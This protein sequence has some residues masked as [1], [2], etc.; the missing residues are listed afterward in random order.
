MDANDLILKH[1][2]LVYKQLH[3]FNLVDDPEAISQGYEALYNAIQSF[4]HE[5][6][7]KFSTYATV[8]IYNRLG[9]YVRSLNTQILQNTMSYES[10][11]GEDGMTILD[12][13]ESD[14]TAD[15]RVLD[16]CGVDIIR[17]ALAECYLDINNELHALIVSIWMSSDF[18]ASYTSIAQTADCTQSYVSQVI[19]TFKNKLKKKL[20]EY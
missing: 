17:N 14:K 15:G 6:G 1:K 10:P 13:L 7:H 19:K 18:K 12:T 11:V 4:D 5:S 2:G 3:K 16:E 9:S 8:C 20:G